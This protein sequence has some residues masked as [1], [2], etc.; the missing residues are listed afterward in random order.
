MSAGEGVGMSQSLRWSFP[1]PPGVLP[2]TFHV[3][4]NSLPHACILL[5]LRREAASGVVLRIKLQIFEV[6]EVINR[7]RGS[8]SC[9]AGFQWALEFRDLTGEVVGKEAAIV[10]VEPLPQRCLG[11]RGSLLADL[12]MQAPSRLEIQKQRMQK[13]IDYRCS[14]SV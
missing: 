1:G 12:I 11:P 9:R 14:R 13:T 6:R 4:T 5:I 8:S 2:P 7:S 3:P 10:S